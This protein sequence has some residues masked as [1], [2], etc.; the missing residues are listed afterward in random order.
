VA[1]AACYEV[2][3][4]AGLKTTGQSGSH[5]R[6]TARESQPFTC[7]RV[8]EGWTARSAG[9]GFGGVVESGQAFSLAPVLRQKEGRTF[10][11]RWA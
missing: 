5:A 8:E 4:C 2:S 6:Y 7:H 10:A 11:F 1:P 9:A 3:R